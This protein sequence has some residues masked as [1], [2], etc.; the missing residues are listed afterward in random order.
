[1]ERIIE[2]R[3]PSEDVVAGRGEE[4]APEW[5]PRTRTLIVIGGALASWALFAGIVYL[6]GM[7]VRA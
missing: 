7:A 3:T 4:R 5:S 6:L 1:M 2:F